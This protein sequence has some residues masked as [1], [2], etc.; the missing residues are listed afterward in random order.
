REKTARPFYSDTSATSDDG[1]D[2]HVIHKNLRLL[3]VLGIE[4][5][6]VTFPFVVDGLAVSGEVQAVAHG[7]PFALINPGAPW[8]NKRWPAARFGEVAAFLRDVRG[9][10]SIVLWGPGEEPLAGEVVTTS[11]GAAR[12]APPTTIAGVIA[13]SRRAALCVS[14]DTGPLHLAA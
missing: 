14:G 9:L 12:L 1:A 5:D 10:Q 8:P 11:D 4:T 2:R 3:R 13:L 7:A 6:R